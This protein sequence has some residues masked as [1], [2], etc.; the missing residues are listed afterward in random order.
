MK[1]VFKY[2]AIGVISIAGFLGLNHLMLNVNNSL[3]SKV[4]GG[5]NLSLLKEI[6]EGDKS[7]T[8]AVESNIEERNRN[9]WDDGL[10][11]EIDLYEKKFLEYKHLYGDANDVEVTKDGISINKFSL[12]D[13][14]KNYI[15]GYIKNPEIK[16]VEIGKGEEKEEAEIIG[17]YGH[18]F[19]FAE[20]KF[21]NDVE[22]TRSLGSNVL[23]K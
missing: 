13:G 18:R 15:Y 19:W 21:G 3:V 7:L 2:V 17:Y 16:A 8:F 14:S 11:L 5:N 4:D 1:K 20:N 10:R 23:S 9:S 22:V 12:K 6:K